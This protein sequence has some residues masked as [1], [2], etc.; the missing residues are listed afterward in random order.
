LDF[1]KLLTQKGMKKM[2]EKTYKNESEKEL[3]ESVRNELQVLSKSYLRNYNK[4]LKLIRKIDR[5]ERSNL[6]ES[7]S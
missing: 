2:N 6:C 4:T 3:F 1:L 7:S 5:Q